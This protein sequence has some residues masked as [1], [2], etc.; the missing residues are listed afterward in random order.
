ML[1]YKDQRMKSFE[2]YVFISLLQFPKPNFKAIR[3]QSW[4]YKKDWGL[5]SVQHAWTANQ[6]K[7]DIWQFAVSWA[8]R[9][10]NTSFE[11]PDI[12]GI[13][14]SPRKSL[15][16][17]FKGFF[18]LN[19]VSLVKVPFLTNIAVYYSVAS[20]RSYVSKNTRLKML[21]SLK[22]SSKTDNSDKEWWLRDWRLKTKLKTK[23]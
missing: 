14:F 6:A 19:C 4:R 2:T 16:V 17:L 20:W 21:F 7:F 15:T 18:S 12:G 1:I 23:Y 3:G 5:E 22:I 9:M 10:H 11:S 8:T 13:R